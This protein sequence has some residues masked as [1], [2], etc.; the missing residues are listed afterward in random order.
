[1]CNMFTFMPSFYF[2]MQ[3]MRIFVPK[4]RMNDEKD[5]FMAADVADGRLGGTGRTETAT[6]GVY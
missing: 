1:M 5:R 3:K 6:G 2:F 4:T